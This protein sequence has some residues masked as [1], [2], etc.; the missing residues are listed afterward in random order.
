MTLSY[1]MQHLP[2]ACR[3]VGTYFYHWAGMELQLNSLIGKALKLEQM[4]E[5]IICANLKFADK[6]YIAKTTVSVA[7][8]LDNDQRTHFQKRLNKIKDQAVWRNMLAHNAFGPL[9]QE[10]LIVEFLVTKAKGDLKFPET[11]WDTSEF[12]TKYREIVDATDLL[13][14]MGEKVAIIPRNSLAG[15]LLR[16]APNP[17]THPLGLAGLL[18]P[19]QEDHTSET[20]LP[21][22]RTEPQTP[23]SSEG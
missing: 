4:A 12:H 9:D 3:Q 23:P 13:I 21:T 18:S 8:F 17:D 6:I 22:D 20:N 2:E 19:S 14:E 5:A 10:D 1:E 11:R 7:P 15:A 16:F